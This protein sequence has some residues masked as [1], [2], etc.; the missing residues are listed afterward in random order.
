[1]SD[2]DIRAVESM[3]R[4][5]MDLETLLKCFPQIP[6]ADIENIRSRIQS[7]ITGNTPAL[8]MNCS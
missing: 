7:Q 5:G 3:A 2:R 6:Q 4:T 1:M 8:K